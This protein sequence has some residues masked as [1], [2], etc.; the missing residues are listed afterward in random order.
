VRIRNGGGEFVAKVK[1][2]GKLNWSGSISLTISADVT[3]ELDWETFVRGSI[4]LEAENDQLLAQGFDLTLFLEFEGGAWWQIVWK[5]LLLE[6][7]S[8]EAK[9]S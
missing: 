5:E 3:Q 1:S 2:E 6:G 9:W 8:L 7:T 4:E